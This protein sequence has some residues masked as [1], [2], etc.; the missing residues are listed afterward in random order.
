MKIYIGKVEEKKTSMFIGEQR[1]KS[2]YVPR[3]DKSIE[4]T[5]NG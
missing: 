4:N 2:C 3:T 1:A 5:Y